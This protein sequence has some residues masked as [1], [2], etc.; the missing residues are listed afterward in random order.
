[1]RDFRTLDVWNRAFDIAGVIYEITE[2]FPKEEKYTLTSQLRRAS[3]SV[4]S[5]IAE[6]CGRRTTKDTIGFM[7]NALGS[8]REVEAQIM[9][10]CDKVK[11]LEKGKAD[12]LI[13]EVVEVSK[14][15]YG[16]IKYIGGRNE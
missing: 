7:F 13:V 4:F 6:G 3:V 10:A 15:L 1:M 16:Y 11:Y 12:V 14:M 9:F 8:L 2:G 5:N